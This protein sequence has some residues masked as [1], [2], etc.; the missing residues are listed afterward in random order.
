MEETTRLEGKATLT[1][2]KEVLIKSVIKAIPTYTMS[3]FE[4]L[5]G[6]IKELEVSIC[7]FWWDNNGDSREGALSQLEEIM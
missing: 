3:C 1:G 5:K 7:K 4:L 2:R 6:L